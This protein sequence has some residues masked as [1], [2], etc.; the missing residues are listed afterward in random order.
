MPAWRRRSATVP[1]SWFNS[2]DILASV[3]A[4]PPLV[5]LWRWQAKRGREPG[6]IAKIGIGSALTGASALFMVAGSL[7]GGPDGRAAVCGRSPAS[8]AWA[9]PSSIIGR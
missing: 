9:S 8:P 3:I 4:V 7:L 2:V 1:A 5:L 6:D